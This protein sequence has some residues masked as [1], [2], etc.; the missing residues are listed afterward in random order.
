MAEDFVLAAIV[1]D[2]QGGK[3]LDDRFDLGPVNRRIAALF[4]F[5][6]ESAFVR[7][8]KTSMSVIRLTPL[9]SS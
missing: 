2:W 4:G 6:V 3:S 8:S 9:I 5:H 1:N 7:Y